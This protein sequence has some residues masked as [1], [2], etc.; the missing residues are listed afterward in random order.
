MGL[1][2]FLT[3]LRQFIW[4]VPCRRYIRRRVS[5]IW[6]EIVSEI[7]RRPVGDGDE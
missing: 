6:P 4:Q 5:A 1:S 3:S 2:A 7:G